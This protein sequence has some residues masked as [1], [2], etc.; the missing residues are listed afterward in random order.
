VAEALKDHAQDD[1]TSELAST[2]KS[3]QSEYRPYFLFGS[4][5]NEHNQLML[6]TKS[7]YMENVDEVNEMTELLLV[8]PRTKEP[9][10]RIHE[11]KSLYAGGGHSALLTNQGDLYI[12]GWNESGQLGRKDETTCEDGNPLTSHLLHVKPLSIKV[13]AA[14]LGHTHTLVIE[15]NTGR[16]FA[17]GENGR[18]QV[19]GLCSDSVCH[20]PQTLLSD[21][22]FIDVAAGLF[23]SAAITLQGELYTWGC[24]RFRQC[25]AVD[26]EQDTDESFTVGRWSPPDGSKMVQVACGRRHTIMLDEHGRV[27]TMGDNKYGQLGRAD[28]E[29]SEDPQLVDGLLGQ[30]TFAIYSGWSHVLALIRNKDDELTLYGWGRNDKGQLG[31]LTQNHCVS[32][33][34]ML[35]VGSENIS[36]QS[37]C[38]GAESSHVLDDSGIIYSSGWNEHGNLGIGH[39][40]DDNC[41]DGCSWRR[42]TG[43][44]V[45]A[46]PSNNMKKILFASG[47]AHLIAMAI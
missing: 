14:D 30:K 28:T 20:E 3:L 32:A 2:V 17:F 18:G 19:S 41:I 12:W 6:N 5:S 33:P 24:G 13:E 21:E 45:V 37:A 36:I 26:S 35:S 31:S 47:G 34:Q 27:W 9:T 43:A 7:E 4:G 46:P 11:P 29:K 15:K 10:Q 1:R 16:L 42:T 22:Q 39:N 8:V 40:N 44:I 38:C 23:H 25:I